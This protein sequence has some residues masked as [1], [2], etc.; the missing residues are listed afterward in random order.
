M[1]SYRMIL[2]CVLLTISADKNNSQDNFQEWRNLQSK[3]FQDAQSGEDQQFS[4]FLRAEWE[5]FEAMEGSISDNT[6]KPAKTPVYKPDNAVENA[7]LKVITKKV[8]L[9]NIDNP[10]SVKKEI[11]KNSTSIKVKNGRTISVSFQNE[12]LSFT[13]DSS[14]PNHQQGAIDKWFVATY[15]E[16]V[17]KTDYEPLIT[18]LYDFRTQMKLNDWGYGILLKDVAVEIYGENSNLVH[19]FTWFMLLKSG[20]EAKVGLSSRDIVLLLPSSSE[21]FGI[22]YYTFSDLNHKYYTI[23]FGEEGIDHNSSLSIYAGK[24]SNDGK[25]LDFSLSEIATTTPRFIKKTLEFKYKGNRYG[26]PIIVDENIANLYRHYPQTSIPTFFSATISP[27]VEV[28]LLHSLEKIIRNKS[29]TEAV[30]L[31]LRFVQTAFKYQTDDEQFGREKYL[32][33][34]ETLYYQICDCED[35]SILFTQLVKR[36]TGLEVIGLDYPGHIATAVSF[37]QPFPGDSIDHN[38]KQYVICDPTYIN[39]DIGMS[40]PMYKNVNPRLIYLTK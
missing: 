14:M 32:I 31:L 39:A 33:P 38:G 15:W 11:I 5:Q 4:E 18:Q 37:S 21:L 3:R 30:N 29:E 2:V 16:N 1:S 13:I 26:V 34:D 9:L 19:L 36:L 22:P 17:T 35:R 12:A 6:P 23:V 28:Q 40:M 7:V 10:K 8:E 25:L 24:Y 27:D 20:Y